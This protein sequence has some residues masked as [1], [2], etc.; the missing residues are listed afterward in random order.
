VIL[1]GG[2]K[3]RVAL[4][5]GLLIPGSILLLDDPIS[6]VDTA[7]GRH[8]SRTI[9][10]LVGRKTV[11]IVSHR[12]SAVRDAHQVITLQ[13]GRLTEQGTHDTLIADGGY[14]ATV[15]ALQELEHAV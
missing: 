15:Y 3:Q 13:N 9:A 2:Q 7:T 8:I 12:M 4:A 10:D 14:Y 6:Q 11:L 1:S 5:R